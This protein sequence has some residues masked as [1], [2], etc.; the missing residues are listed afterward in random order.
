MPLLVNSFFT[1]LVVVSTNTHDT[2]LYTRLYVVSFDIFVFILSYFGNEL[3]VCDDG[4]GDGGED[5][6]FKKDPY[7]RKI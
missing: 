2:F 3:D 4:G 5:L 7:F 1:H 6:E